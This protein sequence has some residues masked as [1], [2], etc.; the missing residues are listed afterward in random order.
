MMK[1][2]FTLLSSTV[3]TSCEFSFWTLTDLLDKTSFNASDLHESVLFE[4][5]GDNPLLLTIFVRG[6]HDTTVL[7]H[8]SLILYA[9][10]ESVF[11]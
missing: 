6:S 8:N 9:N 5:V 1:V 3:H 10:F 4:P 11:A 7:A 2:G